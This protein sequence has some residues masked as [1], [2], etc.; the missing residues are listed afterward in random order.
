M[1]KECETVNFL[2]TRYHQVLISNFYRSYTIACKNTVAA[3][4]YLPAPSAK[5]FSGCGLR[6]F[7]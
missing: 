3:A 5:P 6:G 4:S 2:L 7:S 1:W